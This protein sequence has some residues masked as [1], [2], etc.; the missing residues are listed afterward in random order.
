MDIY[1]YITIIIIGVGFLIWYLVALPTEKRIEMVKKFLLQAVTEAEKALG[2][3]SGKAKLSYVYTE[4]IKAFPV[5]SNFIKFETFEIL[6]DGALKEM[7]KLIE[8]SVDFKYYVR[9]NE[10]K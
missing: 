6:V 1:L 8:E 3:Q 9:Y 7:E 4:F 2:S 5:L 10:N